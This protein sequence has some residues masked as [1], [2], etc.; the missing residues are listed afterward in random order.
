MEKMRL[1]S[2]VGDWFRPTS[3]PANG[4]GSWGSTAVASEFGA[5]NGRHHESA[6]GLRSD[7]AGATLLT[8][9]PSEARSQD[10]RF[11][12]I[13]ALVDSMQSHFAVQ[14]T[15]TELIAT[16]LERLA[17]SLS[18][19]PEVS[20]AQLDIL[21]TIRDGIDAASGRSRRLEESLAQLPQLAD[22]QRE[23][24]ASIGRQLDLSRQTNDHASKVIDRFQQAVSALGDATSASATALRQLHA[25]SAAKEDRMVKVLEQQTKRFTFFACVAIAAALLAAMM[26]LAAAMVR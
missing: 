4:N 5:P 24:M 1:W 19:L 25:D 12:K 11:A 16:S 14:D 2:R 23:T 7:D 22:A 3:K 6:S 21:A 9:R 17:S 26:G 8:R 20:K 15:R 18:H 13:E 10:D